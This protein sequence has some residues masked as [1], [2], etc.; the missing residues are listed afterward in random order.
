MSEISLIID[1]RGNQYILN[2]KTIE[3]QGYIQKPSEIIVNNITQNYTDFIIYNLTKEQNNII[4]KWDNNL[5]NCNSMFLNLT[6]ITNIDLSKLNSSNIR[7]MSNMFYGC[8]SLLLVNLTNFYISPNINISG[9]FSHCNS[10]IYLDF[11]NFNI[12]NEINIENI[13]Y[14]VNQDLIYCINE[15]LFPNHKI[16]KTFFNPNTN[17]CSDICFQNLNKIKF[18][19]NKT[20]IINCNESNIYKFEYF[21][22]CY[23]LCPL[24]TIISPFNNNACAPI[25]CSNKYP[26]LNSNNE[27]VEKCNSNDLFPKRCLLRFLNEDDL[28][29]NNSNEL[30][31]E[32]TFYTTIP[33]ESTILY[34]TLPY[35]STILYTTLPYESTILYTTLPYESTILYTTLPYESTILYTTLP[36]ESTILYTTLP[37][38]STI[39]Y[40]TL[41]YESTILYTTLPYE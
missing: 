19:E 18:T 38:E 5:I 39:L 3:A 25:K 6:N 8:S 27:C 12:S 10:L 28:D 32:N 26:Y 16:F 24:N 17:N 41:P 36:Y 7:T 2:N 20:C 35:E 13:F 14:G 30:T 34:T 21:N 9:M 15:T 40:T 4:I 31:I 11:R 1:G 33:Y 29:E 37:Y 23:Q 22:I